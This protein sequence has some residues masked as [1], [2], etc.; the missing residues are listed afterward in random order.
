MRYIHKKRGTVYERV[1]TGRVQCDQPMSD[2]DV[3]V[4]YRA[5]DGSLWVRSVTE[6]DERFVEEK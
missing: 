3:V 4:I 2:Y 5:T 6:F 1:G